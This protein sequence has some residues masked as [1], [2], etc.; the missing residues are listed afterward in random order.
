MR[1]A[2]S[3]MS[4]SNIAYYTASVILTVRRVTACPFVECRVVAYSSHKT[5][6]SPSVRKFN[7]QQAQQY[8]SHA[9]LKSQYTNFTC[10]WILTY[11]SLSILLKSIHPTCKLLLLLLQT[12]PRLSRHD[13]ACSLT[14]QNLAL[15]QSQSL[16]YADTDW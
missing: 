1:L 16:L 10:V 6:A 15:L 3:Q 8:E 2:M 12:H 14:S 11:R 13:Y 7:Y 9:I 4:A 5:L